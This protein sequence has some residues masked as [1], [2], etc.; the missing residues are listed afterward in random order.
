MFLRHRGFVA[1]KRVRSGVKMSHGFD[2]PTSEVCH[3][4]TSHT[5]QCKTFYV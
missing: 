2:D 4:N 5:A 1:E 3:F